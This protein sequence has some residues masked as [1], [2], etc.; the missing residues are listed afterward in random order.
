M[1]FNLPTRTST[2]RTQSQQSKSPQL[3]RNFPYSEIRP[4]QKE[5][6]E[7][8]E[9]N[10]TNFDVFVIQAPTAAGKSALAKSVLNAC[11][12]ASYLTPTNLLVSQF[13]QEFPDTPT[14]S[15]MDSY[16]CAEWQRPCVA[17][18]ARLRS[19][20]RGCK[21]SKDLSQAHYG[22]G[23]GVYN[24]HT[25]LAH[26]VYR[27]VLVVDEAHNLIHQ[28]RERLS[29][30]LWKHD[31][32]YPSNMWKP[33]QVQE[34][35]RT[36]SSSRQKNKAVSAL[37]EAAKYEAPEFIWQRTK[38]WFNGKGTTRNEPEERE[39]IKLY[40]VDISQAVPMFWPKEVEKIVL[41]SAT[42]GPKDIEALGLHRKRVCYVACKSPIPAE[43]RP[44]VPLNLF[45]VNRSSQESVI[46]DMAEA[47]NRIAE[48]HP[49][50]KGVVHVTYSLSQALEKLLGGN[51]RYL[52]HNKYNKSEVYKQFLQSSP[53]SGTV[54][55]ACGM[56]EG[57]DLPEDL[58]R[59][60]II[61]KVP[62][63]SLE[64]PAIKYLADKDPT[65]YAWECLKHTIQACGRVCR[66][67]QDYGSTFILD[68]SFYRLQKEASHLM[69]Q[70]FLDAIVLNSDSEAYKEKLK[71]LPE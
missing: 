38:D 40:P 18:R 37:R 41:L 71:L 21:C 59:W 55:F 23:P 35:I 54:L 32:K 69:P 31:Y 43:S 61:A 25:Y 50:E 28:I 26:K 42:I 6:L 24:Y 36:L 62:W 20:C 48:D 47:I 56:Y 17:T 11:H 67:P 58:G 5:V 2:A 63:P 1:T 15:R 13:L 14:M 57:M 64:S 45:S 60:Q 4:L 34:W 44:V 70:W 66:T 12:S 7:T 27:K 68:R 3:V 51:P 19:Y 16:Q 53:E 49:G 9:S 46:P 29:L 30:K 8:L 33:E 10:W 22:R 39:L 65:W 52:F